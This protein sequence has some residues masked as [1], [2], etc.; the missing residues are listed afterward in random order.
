VRA[1]G[2]GESCSQEGA[3]RTCCETG[4][5][6]CAGT[7]EFQQWG[8]CLGPD[9]Q[10]VTCTSGGPEDCKSGEFSQFCDGGR[11]PPPP[12]G[13]CADNEFSSCDGGP[14][15]PPTSC[16]D[17]EFPGCNDKGD[18]GL[19]PPPSLCMKGPV[20]NEPEILVG[21]SPDKGETVSESGQI[22]VWVNDER[23]EFIASNEQIDMKTGK[24]TAPG[25]RTTKAQDG[26]LWEPALYIAPMT[27][28]SGG[29]PHF[30][31]Y[32]KGWYNN[33]PPVNGTKFG[34]PPKGVQVP[35]MDPV[36]PGMALVEMYS[37]ENI[38][39]VDRL[40]LGPGTYIGEFVIHDGDHDRAVGCVTI[41]ITP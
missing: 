36:P 38:W 27:A 39:D 15:P 31:Q 4:H 5:Q 34:G 11:P 1:D 32:I 16:D 6:T 25:D 17:S 37:S 19:P 21:Y 26:Y 13:S 33:M 41:T 40:G 23:P 14:P 29:T 8:P 12:P 7:A 9:G 18:G 2:V 24:I 28:E 30:P 3:T 10:Q 20:N 35:G 22:K